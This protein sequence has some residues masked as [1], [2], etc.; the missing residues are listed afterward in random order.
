MNGD[1]PRLEAEAQRLK[2]EIDKLARALLSTDDKPQ[3]LVK[4]MAERE[5][6]LAAIRAQLASMKTAPQVLDLEAR[7]MEKEARRRIEDVRDVMGRRGEAAKRALSTLLDGKLTFTPLPDKRYEIT[8]RIVTGSLVHL[9][10]CPQRES[11][12]R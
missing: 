7:R 3:T 10:G 8:G 5:D 2:G 6:T 4:M 1:S 11:N 12:P 9:P